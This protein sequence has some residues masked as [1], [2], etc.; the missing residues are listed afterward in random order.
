M[1]FHLFAVLNM[2]LSLQ[3]WTRAFVH[4][5]PKNISIALLLLL[6]TARYIKPTRF[7]EQTMP[8]KMSDPVFATPFLRALNKYYARYSLLLDEVSSKRCIT[9]RASEIKMVKKEDNS[10]V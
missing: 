1:L 3:E 6:R 10:N 4:T 8:S 7:I 2:C 9:P 5:I